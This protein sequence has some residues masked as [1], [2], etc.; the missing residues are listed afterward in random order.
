MD[1]AGKMHIPVAFSRVI[2]MHRPTACA[3]SRRAAEH[4]PLLREVLDGLRAGQPTLP[5][6][7]FYDEYG[8]QLYEQITALDEYYPFRAEVEI[9]ERYGPAIARALGE[10]VLVV[11]YGSG[12]SVKTRLLLDC[13]HAC[14]GYLPIDISREHLAQAARGIARH[15][16]DL[17]VEHLCADFTEPLRLPAHFTAQRRRVAFFPGSTIGNFDPPAATRLLRNIRDLVGAGGRLLVGVD[18]P[19]DRATLERAYDDPH[20]VTARFNR[21]ILTHINRLFGADFDPDCF[22]HEAIWNPQR[23]RVE[24]HLRCIRDHDATLAGERI[25]FRRGQSIWTES[26]HKY[27]PERFQEIC[28]MAGFAAETVWFDDRERYTLHLMRAV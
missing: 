28:A 13:L 18:I 23:S 9:L 4:E 22:H 20:G 3:A 5:C 19:K 21:N 6:K 26:S 2:P 12:S 27:P 11:E 15:Y 1:A 14:A 16:P 24:M 17:P 7:L 25:A 10:G 8:S